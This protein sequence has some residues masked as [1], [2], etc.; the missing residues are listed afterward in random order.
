MQPEGEHGI[1]KT[2]IDGP[3][4]NLRQLRLTVFLHEDYPNNEVDMPCLQEETDRRES[5]RR[6]KE[7]P[8]TRA[9]DE[10]IQRKIEEDKL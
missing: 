10:L 4:T 9:L 8:N 1:E 6:I 3:I 2:R 7:S 5:W